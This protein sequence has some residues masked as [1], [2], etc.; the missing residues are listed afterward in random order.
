MVLLCKDPK[1]EKVMEPSTTIASAMK[2]AKDVSAH[3]TEIAGLK[4]QIAE[5]EEKLADQVATPAY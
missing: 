4:Q 5:L 2:P 1:G 3:T